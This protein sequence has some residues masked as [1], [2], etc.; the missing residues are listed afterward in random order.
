MVE[1]EVRGRRVSSEQREG[2]GCEYFGLGKGR[3]WRRKGFEEKQIL[4]IKVL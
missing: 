3:L 1:M 2:K 4:E